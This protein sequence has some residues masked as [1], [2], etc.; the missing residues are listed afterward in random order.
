MDGWHGGWSWAQY[1]ATKFA[2]RSFHMY[3]QKKKQMIINETSRRESVGTPISN[4]QGTFSSML[5]RYVGNF[6]PMQLIW[7]RSILDECALLPHIEKCC[8]YCLQPAEVIANH[9]PRSRNSNPVISFQFPSKLVRRVP[10]YIVWQLTTACAFAFP[11]CPWIHPN[12]KLCHFSLLP[13]ERE[14]VPLPTHLSTQTTKR[15]IALPAPS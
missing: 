12:C 9:L 1:F 10:I 3:S 13:L 14:S 7:L 11:C 2:F 6:N 8:A 4:S 15:T 5:L